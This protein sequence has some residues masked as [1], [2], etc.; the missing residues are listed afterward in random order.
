MQ[1]FRESNFLLKNLT[2]DWF[3]EKILLGSEFLVF[4]SVLNVQIVEI[5]SHLNPFGK[6]VREI[7]LFTGITKY[8]SIKSKLT[9]FFHS[10]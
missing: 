2:L 5:Y 10:V 7:N 4:H 1:K 6:K 3:D 9:S 8:F